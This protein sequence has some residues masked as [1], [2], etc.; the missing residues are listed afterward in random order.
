MLFRSY[1]VRNPQGLAFHPVTGALWETEHGPRAG[2]EVNII[3][4]GKNYGWPRIAY[5][6][7]YS[8]QPVNG[9]MTAQAG[10]EQ[11]V[12]YWDPAIAPSGATFYGAD[13]VPEWKNNLFVAAHAGQH[14]I[15]L[16]IEGQRIVGEERLLLDQRQRMR[17][18]RQGPDDALWVVTDDQSDGRLIR[19]SARG[20]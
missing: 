10:M 3:E 13:A 5:G 8:G 4:P 2:D 9:G 16:V 18:V 14:L 12:Y 7:E 1:G 11:P 15:R 19:L 17:D 20:R 6:T